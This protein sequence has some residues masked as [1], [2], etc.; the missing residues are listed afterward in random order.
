MDTFRLPVSSCGFGGRLFWA[1]AGGKTG[2]DGVNVVVVGASAVGDFG[3]GVNI[4]GFGVDVAV[5]GA[6][7]V[8]GVGVEAGDERG[9][10]LEGRE[11]GGVLVELGHVEGAGQGFGMLG[12]EVDGGLRD[13]LAGLGDVAEGFALGVVEVEQER[14]VRADGGDGGGDVGD[15]LR[16]ERGADDVL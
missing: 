4:E 9:D 6:Q 5:K 1:R 15:G 13:A 10:L 2:F 12:D 7:G 14:E 11:Q 16:G 3:G 8:V